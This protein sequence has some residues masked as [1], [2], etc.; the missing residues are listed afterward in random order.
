MGQTMV[1]TA[2][3]I[4]HNVPG[5]CTEKWSYTV[6]GNAWSSEV[7]ETNCLGGDP[8]GMKRT[9]TFSITGKRMT[10]QSQ[11]STIVMERQ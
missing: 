9:G 11:G 1:I 2:K 8:V 6:N 5:F 10:W 4:T 3:T 7:I